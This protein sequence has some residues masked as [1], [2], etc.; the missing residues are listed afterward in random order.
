MVVASMLSG[1]Q[2]IESLTGHWR[3]CEAG[4]VEVGAITSADGVGDT[5]PR[6]VEAGRNESG[7]LY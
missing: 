4:R 3:M 7:R 6:T 2:P 5:R 1:C